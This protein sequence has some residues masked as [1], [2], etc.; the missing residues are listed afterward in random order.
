MFYVSKMSLCTFSTSGFGEEMCFLYFD[1]LLTSHRC[2]PSAESFAYWECDEA[3]LQAVEQSDVSRVDQLLTC[4]TMKPPV[5]KMGDR[6]PLVLAC[7][8]GVLDGNC[9]I[10][11]VLPT[12]GLMLSQQNV[13]SWWL[14]N[15]QWLVAL[16]RPFGGGR[17]PPAGPGPRG[18]A[19]RRE[20]PPAAGGG[21]WPPGG[22]PK[23]AGSQGWS[24][25]TAWIWLESLTNCLRMWA[26]QGRNSFNKKPFGKKSVGKEWICSI[27]SAVFQFPVEWTMWTRQSPQV[28][29]LLILAGVDPNSARRRTPLQLASWRSIQKS[30]PPFPW[31]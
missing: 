19:S 17:T 12:N 8:Q 24:K 5:V 29:R 2:S 21:A 30:W 4:A 10:T 31:A 15:N 22:G 13:A 18:V 3:L 26:S 27:V 6:K 25:C 16:P 7:E 23:I 9:W 11:R 28:V 14:Q 20:E 1:M